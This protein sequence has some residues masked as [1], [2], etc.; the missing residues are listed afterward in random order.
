MTDL[1]RD[2]TLSSEADGS[3]TLTLS[4]AWNVWGPNGGYLASIALRA[5]GQ[6]ARIARPVSLHVHYVRA[7]RAEVPVRLQVQLVQSG[8]KAESLSVSMEQDG[9]VVLTALVR[10]VAEGPGLAHVQLEAPV[11]L[12]PLAAIDAEELW[13]EHV[14]RYPFWEAFDRRVLQPDA[15]RSQRGPLP[16]RWLEWF[17][18]RTPVPKDAF[19]E[20]A[21]S[22][23][24]ID[25]LCW[26]AAWLLHGK[27]QFIAPSLD[28]TVWFHQAPVSE[29]LLADAL[30][31]VARGGLVAGSCQ[32]W[33][34]Q[35][36]LVATGGSQLLCVPAPR[37]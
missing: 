10:T 26:P 21:R 20:A 33:N 12:D 30:A 17:R 32:V 36:E 28:L 29:W 2:T 27:E 14:A 5:A 1:D 15:W 37:A 22:V 11:V 8:Q 13:R 23:L 3:F 35:R 19:L 6:L 4:S 24:L 31:P 25:T 9:K 34:E 18:Q 7:T 16:P